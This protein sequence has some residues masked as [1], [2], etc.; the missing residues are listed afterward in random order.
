M[1][2]LMKDPEAVLDYSGR[3][4]LGG[5]VRGL[6][7]TEGAIGAHNAGEWL[8]LIEHD[9]LRLIDVPAWSVGSQVTARL[10]QPEANPPTA[11]A[12]VGP[13]VLRPLRGTAVFLDGVKVVGPR[14]PAIALPADGSTVDS[15]ARS[16]LDAVLSA[17][18]SHGLIEI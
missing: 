15:E 18:R 16:T 14:L 5:L 7:G 4:R 11:Q 2:L 6:D 10:V 13:E 1:T 9:A 17:L 8:V 3:F 12:T